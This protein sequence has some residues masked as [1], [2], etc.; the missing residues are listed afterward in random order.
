MR[1]F[2]GHRVTGHEDD[3]VGE[4]GILRLKPFEDLLA[5]QPRHF[6]IAQGPRY[7]EH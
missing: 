5:V 4:C 3:T 6:P 2:F 7:S 1:V